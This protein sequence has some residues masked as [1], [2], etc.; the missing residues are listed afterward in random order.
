MSYFGRFNYDYKEKYLLEATLRRDGSSRFGA[1]SRWGTFL[2]FSAAWR[3]SEENYM[4]N[5]RDY[6]NNL[7]LRVGWGQSG[8]DEVGNYN[9]FSSFRSNITNASYPITGST[10]SPTVGFYASAI[11]NPDAKW[12]TTSTT[13]IGL[14]IAVLKNSL[15]ATID[16]WQRKTTDML[17]T[18]SIPMVVGA[19]HLSFRVRQD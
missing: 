3:I 18:L 10:T 8:N 5:A 15:S 17:Y 6:I 9:G 19:A 12:E 13:N 1:N 16:V 7:K 4:V 11:G 2:S 14:D